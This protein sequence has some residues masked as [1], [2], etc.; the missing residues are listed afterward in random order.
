MRA[1]TEDEVRARLREA[2]ARA[3]GQQR[4][5]EAHDISPQYVSDVLLNRRLP[6]EKILVALGLRRRTVY[7]RGADDYSEA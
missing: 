1:I 7:E 4:W 3:Q 5:A 2:V 6:G